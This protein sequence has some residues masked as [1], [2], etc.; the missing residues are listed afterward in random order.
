MPSRPSSSLKTSIRRPFLVF[1]GLLALTL[2]I[3]FYRSFNPDC[4][5]FSNDGPLGQAHA[6]WSRVPAAFFGIWIDLNDIGFSGG[7]AA[8]SISC[9]VSWL[10]GPFGFAKFYAPICLFI[11]GLGAWT[12]FRQLK[13]SPLAAAL[14]GLAAALNSD[15]FGTACWGVASQQ[16]A[17]GM[18]FFALALVVSNSPKTPALVRWTRLALAGLAVGIN[19][20]EAADI[21]ALFSLCVAAFVF[22]KAIA[23]ADGS[24][25]AKIGR[26][27]GSVLIIAIFAGFIATQTI[28]SLVG[29]QI[30]GI[31]GTA[32][33]AKIRAAHWDWGTEWSEP[34]IETLDLFV[35]GLFGYKMD[36]P[37]NMMEFMQPYYKSGNYWG[38]VGRDPNTD[39]FF[40]RSFQPGDEVT[41][42]ISTPDHPGQNAALTIGPDGNVALPLI[43]QI[44][45]AGLSG[46]KLKETID[47][48]YAS[49]EIAGSVVLP[50]NG[51]MRFT[52]HGSDY[53][54]ILVAL[55]AVWAVAQS[56]RRRDSL[57]SVTQRRLIWFWSALLIVSLLLAFGRFAPFNLPV[58]YEW[59]YNHLPGVSSVRNPNKFLY[60]FSWAI[61]ILFAYGADALNR[62]HMEA[63]AGK[64][65]TPPPSWWKNGFNRK[66]AIGCGITFVGCV[67]AWLVYASQK[68]ALVS[69]MQAV[70]VSGDPNEL[71]A[72]SIGQA[73]WF[74][75]FFAAAILLCLLVI[76]GV[77]SGPRAR[78][79]GILLGAL[80]VVDLGRADL[81]YIIHWNYI[82]K[83]D[84]DPA[85]H[86]NSTNPVIN[87]LRAHPYE[88]RVAVLPFRMPEQ[89]S[90]F[91]QLYNIEW[92]QHQFP[93]YNIQSINIVQ[94]SRTAADLLAYQSAFA[95][96]N[97]PE[98]ITRRWQLTNT[99]YL[100]GP[101]GF[102]DVMNSQLDPVQQRFRIVERFNVRLKPGVL[103]FHQ[104]L[105]ELT[106]I[107]DT[108]G[109]YALFDF[110]GALP[111][112]KLYTGWQVCS[113]TAATLEQ[114][115][116]GL[117]PYL[118]PDA[119]G[120]L[121]NL[122]VVDQSTLKTL[123]ETNF[124]PQ[125]T[126]LL[127]APLPSAPV[128]NATHE[129]PG[130]VEFKSYS[131][132]D[133]VFD[134]T[135]TAPSVLLLNDKYDPNWRVTVDGKPADLL[136][137]NFIMRGVYLT[138]GRHTVEFQFSLSPKPLYITL[139]AI[140]VGILLCGFL[141]VSSR[142]AKPPVEG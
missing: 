93:Y 83:Y 96:G 80:L 40:D 105:S 121:T 95:M 113:N 82:Q 117:Q 26:G 133:I 140:G 11:L 108:N 130:T 92:A 39:R 122:N 54:G 78:L 17:I 123:A 55:V 66:W 67:L 70:E 22:Y 91:D 28:L 68:T 1:A 18:D 77:F 59:L 94:A 33:D 135:A 13:L 138:P 42:G 52:G 125:Q 15:F 27:T 114:W 2:C 115:H 35:P 87:L 101:A 34:K 100:L 10:F 7:A 79:G 71:A 98:T 9:L 136:R 90:V 46:L 41:V 97:S 29:T 12:F 112:A 75:A 137:C 32:P 139:S 111:R 134:A 36:T 25:V 102:L 50:G 16:I 58:L 99:R 104:Q 64:T 14:G 20:M 53:A 81:P 37:N 47:Q 62:R 88:H 38:G 73:G 44:K 30:Q 63:P 103:E 142:R 51:A 65:K 118:P 106:A 61:V 69:Y 4:V 49:K 74:L 84:M 76:A 23:E 48:A 131:P 107:P 86:D 119:Y 57:F 5:V 8:P 56:L 124:D 120:T 24:A 110:T 72:F 19:V 128:S 6:S 43:G 3:L 141:L 85:N 129:N 132:K 60:V 89:F 126:V 31:V 21:G 127:S 109:D 45:A 116:A